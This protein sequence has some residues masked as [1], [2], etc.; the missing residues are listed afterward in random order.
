VA[1]HLS[2]HGEYV[3]W[4]DPAPAEKSTHSLRAEPEDENRQSPRWECRVCATGATS[5]E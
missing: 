5:V 2:P 1:R 3:L 4:K